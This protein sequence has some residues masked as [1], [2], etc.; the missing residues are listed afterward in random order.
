MLTKYTEY[1][2]HLFVRIFSVANFISQVKIEINISI[3]T[4]D[5]ALFKCMGYEVFIESLAP[6]G[7]Q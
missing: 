4:I 1:L 5:T 7:S 6:R 3:D 2:P